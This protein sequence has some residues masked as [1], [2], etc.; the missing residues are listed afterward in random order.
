[1]S[2]YNIRYTIRVK[3]SEEQTDFLEIFISETR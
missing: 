2:E 3:H 1:M